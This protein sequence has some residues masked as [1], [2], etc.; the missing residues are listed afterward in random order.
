M[1][2]PCLLSMMS[3]SF[4]SQKFVEEGIEIEIAW[5]YVLLHLTRLQWF[6]FKEDL[7]TSF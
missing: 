7:Y 6:L 4:F 2:V 5:K 3:F 1:G